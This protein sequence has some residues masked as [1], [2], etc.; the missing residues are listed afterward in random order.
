MA[1][2]FRTIALVLL[3][4]AP[5]ARAEVELGARYWG[6]SGMTRWAHNAQGAQPAFGNPTSILTYSNLDANAGELYGRTDFGERWFVKGTIGVGRINTG[7][8]DDEDYFSGQVKF[9]D[10]TSSVKGD[11]IAYGGL[12]LGLEVWRSRSSREAL[13][14]FV[15][16]QRWTERVNAYGVT[17]TVGGIGPIGNDVLVLTNEVTWTSLRLGL[18]GR[19]ALG[20]G[21]RLTGEVALIPY[22]RLRNEDSHHLRQSPGDLGPVPN[23]ITEG[24]GAGVQAEV[25]LRW[26]FYDGFEVA[27]GGRYWRLKSVSGTVSFGGGS[28]PLVFQESE[29]SGVTLSL[30]KL[31]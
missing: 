11:R 21:L 24:H 8:F 12:D 6:S 3:L 29:R 23:V 28:F 16:A 15:G 9:S 18:E 17:A 5:L 19:A 4:A 25:E 30:Y 1:G 14:V 26:A 22:A 20:R 31:W 13:A 2:K 27:L 10:T 7:D